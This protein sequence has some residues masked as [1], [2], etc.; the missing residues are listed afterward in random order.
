LRRSK[1][2]ADSEFPDGAHTIDIPAYMVD[3]L[4]DLAGS[5][6]RRQCHGPA[7]APGPWLRTRCSASEIAHFEYTN[8]LAAEGMRR[9]IFGLRPGMTDNE[10]ASLCGL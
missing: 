2:F 1:Y 8:V 9:M 10:L 3:T 4:R 5:R 7:D 6:V